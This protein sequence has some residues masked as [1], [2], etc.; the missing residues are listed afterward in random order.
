[1]KR[2][3]ASY[4]H[5]LLLALF[6][7]SLAF[8][9]AMFAMSVKMLFSSGLTALGIGLV[10]ST[11]GQTALSL[12]AG[13]TADKVPKH[14]IMI[15]CFALNAVGIALALIGTRVT[16]VAAFLL[17]GSSM[18]LFGVGWDALM[19]RVFAESDLP[20]ANAIATT[21][22]TGAM[23]LGPAIGGVL[24]FSGGPAAPLWAVLAISVVGMVVAWIV[25]SPHR[26]TMQPPQGG[27]APIWDSVRL[28]VREKTIYWVTFTLCLLWLGIGGTSA[29]EVPFVTRV[30][31]GGAPA[32]ALLGSL[33]ALA[34]VAGSVAFERLGRAV[35]PVAGLLLGVGC[36]GLGWLFFA[37]MHTLVWAYAFACLAAIGNTVLNISVL[38]LIQVAAPEDQVG[39]V[40]GTVLSVFHVFAV[41]SLIFAPLL[42]ASLGVARTL[43]IEGV[44]ALLA[45]VPGV[46]LAMLPRLARSEA[47]QTADG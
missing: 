43:E 22:S 27:M 21:A 24:R 19:P 26:G 4:L 12:V 35:S 5:P 29:L 9:I 2:D 8:A 30:L 13:Q 37:M 17:V 32:Y 34:M 6:L 45:V 36:M 44:F 20:R 33:T 15:G 16:D 25:S 18:A 42:A 38:S 47:V 11:V 3:R 46:R 28:M 39:S 14:L 31:S 10:A 7:E 23:V 40:I 1:V 41:G